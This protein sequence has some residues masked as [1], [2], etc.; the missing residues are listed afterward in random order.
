MR[1]KW[2]SW[3]RK[4]IGFQSSWQAT[5]LKHTWILL[6]R[7]YGEGISS[8]S[9]PLPPWSCKRHI[10]LLWGDEREDNAGLSC[11]R[12]RLLVSETSQSS[13]LIELILLENGFMVGT[14]ILQL[15]AEM[16]SMEKNCPWKRAAVQIAGEGNW[17]ADSLTARLP[18]EADSVLANWSEDASWGKDLAAEVQTQA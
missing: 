4:Q 18:Q 5:S 3:V 8:F 13:P 15:F 1:K 14:C 17:Q 10:C 9:F 16:K 6:F 2:L 7:V 12:S 11:W